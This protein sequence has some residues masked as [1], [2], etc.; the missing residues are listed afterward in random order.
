VHLWIVPVRARADLRLHDVAHRYIRFVPGEQPLHREAT[1]PLSRSSATPMNGGSGSKPDVPPPMEPVKT[2]VHR[3]Y[4][5]GNHLAAA[6][7]L[8]SGTVL[9]AMVAAGAVL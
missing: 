8:S 1:R 6:S 3:Y 7:A 5:C 2:P 9:N 4:L